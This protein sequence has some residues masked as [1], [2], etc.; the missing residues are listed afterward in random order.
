MT[1]SVKATMRTALFKTNLLTPELKKKSELL[2]GK[3]ATRI[4]TADRG[5]K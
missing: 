4:R 5:I 2:H 3:V 1:T